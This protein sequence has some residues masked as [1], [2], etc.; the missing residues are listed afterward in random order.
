MAVKNILLLSSLM[1]FLVNPTVKA[2]EQEE[3]ITYEPPQETLINGI[4]ESKVP[5]PR[6]IGYDKPIFVKYKPN[7]SAKTIYK[8]K[9]IASVVWNNTRGSSAQPIKLDIKNSNKVGSEFNGSIKFTGEIKAGI[10]G[11]IGTE[12]SGGAKEIREANE[13]V[14]WT[15]GSYKVP[16]KKWGGID[17]WWQGRSSHG[18]LGVKYVDTGSSSGYT[19]VRYIDMDTKVHTKTSKDIYGESWSGTA[20]R[21]YGENSYGLVVW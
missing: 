1:F 11:K 19:S 4:K 2:E 9:K 6:I 14:G 18:S 15:F 13:A 16:A 10:L 21:W 5:N 17:A 20:P 12:V 8:F 3:T 7:A